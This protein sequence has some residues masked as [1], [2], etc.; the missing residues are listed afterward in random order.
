MTQS[1]KEVAGHRLPGFHF[2]GNEVLALLDK[3]VHFV[4][5]RIPPETKIGFKAPVD[6]ILME[7]GNDEALEDGAPG[8]VVDQT[9]WR[10]NSK[11]VAEKTRI[12]KVE[13][14]G[15]DEPFPEVSKVWLQEENE[16][17]RLENRQPAPRRCVGYAA[18]GR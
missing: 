12:E 10:S 11:E 18:I 8:S 1:R 9:F 3:D 2:H 15:L 16:K 13:L 5:R 6:E 7:L 17:A 14:W 4:P